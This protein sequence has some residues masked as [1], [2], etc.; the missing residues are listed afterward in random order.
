MILPSTSLS[1]H[2]IAIPFC[3]INGT[4]FPN[5]SLKQT[6]GFPILLYSHQSLVK[7]SWIT[8]FHDI[9][10]LS[11][12]FAVNHHIVF[13][14]IHFLRITPDNILKGYRIKNP[15]LPE[16]FPGHSPMF[17]LHPAHPVEYQRPWPISQISCQTWNSYCSLTGQWVDNP[18]TI[19]DYRISFC[20]SG[21]LI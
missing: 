12:C 20:P 14:G 21:W 1:S 11:T 19:Q 8:T 6:V 15:N 7:L 17:P 18:R 16:T 3:P 5:F 10:I 2:P 4:T 13:L 9:P